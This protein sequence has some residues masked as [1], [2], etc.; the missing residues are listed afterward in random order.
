MSPPQNNSAARADWQADLLLA[1]QALEGDE[2][3]AASLRDH[4]DRLIR[5]T[6]C[7]RGASNTEA[8]DVLADLWADCFGSSGEPLLKKYQGRCALSSWLITVAT[9]RLIDFKRRKSFQ[10]ELP[11][12]V[13]E[14]MPANRIDQAKDSQPKQRDMALLSVLRGA[15]SQAFASEP[16]ETLLMLKLVH[17]YD[18]TQRELGRIWNWHESKVSRTLDSARDKIRVAIL[19]QVRR[20]DPWLTLEWDDFRELAMWAP[21]L[22]SSVGSKIEMQKHVSS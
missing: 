16:P 14:T 1:K 5:A 21:T 18:V 7:K 10:Q 11:E 8:E 9:N 4:Y 17:M 3:A 22:I 6:L 13:V 15:V 19:A 2:K 20:T 12:G